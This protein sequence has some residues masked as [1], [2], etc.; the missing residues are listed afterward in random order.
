MALNTGLTTYVTNASRVTIGPPVCEDVV[1]IVP[2]FT[3]KGGESMRDQN[4]ASNETKRKECSA[5]KAIH[6]LDCE[7]Q[8]YSLRFYLL[9]TDVR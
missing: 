6:T 2:S 7:N 5:N 4:S 9:F 3:N 8:E 1:G